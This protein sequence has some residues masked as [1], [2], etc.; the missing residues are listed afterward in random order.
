MDRGC[1]EPSDER[2]GRREKA[3][4]HAVSQLKRAA[5]IAAP[6]SLDD[7]TWQRAISF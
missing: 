3:T 4:T 1:R 2:L 5:T 6:V 7:L